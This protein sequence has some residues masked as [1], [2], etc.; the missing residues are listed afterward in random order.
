[1][2]WLALALGCSDLP[3]QAPKQV[4]DT[5]ESQYLDLTKDFPPA[6]PGGIE[7]RTPDF[8]VPPYTELLKC[9]YGTYTGPTVGVRF[10]QPLQADQYSHHNQLKT[11]PDD[12]DW[13]DGTLVD[14]DE[15]G[16]MSKYVPLFEAVGIEASSETAEGNWLD[17]PE[18]VAMRFESG[19]KWVLDIHYINTS[20]KTL[21]V[22]NG[23]NLDYIPEDEVEQWAASIQ[24]DAGMPDIPP[25]E[26]VDTTF[27]CPFPNDGHVLSMLGHMHARGTRYVVDKVLEDGGL[28]RVYE[29]PEWDGGYH[30]YYP[31]IE[32][33]SPGTYAVQQGE[34]L[35]TTC[36]WY[37]YTDTHLGFPEEMC[38]TVIVMYPL[39]RPLLCVNGEYRAR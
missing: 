22:N 1:M 17:L 7:I 18:G 29:V 38:T 27:R 35:E 36:S 32:N 3:K 15:L 25:G 28:E 9:Y 12:E 20:D 19:Q 37:N 21:L 31:V 16:D 6:P 33:W 39:E 26:A 11:V 24:F 14:C 4:E 2:L 10:M 8:E 30:P 23:V 13:P 34:E 5:G